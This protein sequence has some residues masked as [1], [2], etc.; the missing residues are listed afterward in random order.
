MRSWGETEACGTASNRG[1]CV[2]GRAVKRHA[3][4]TMSVVVDPNDLSPLTGTP[5][6]ARVSKRQLFETI[7]DPRPQRRGGLLTSNPDDMV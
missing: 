4:S 1:L 2:R 5:M 7:T 6:V 3:V